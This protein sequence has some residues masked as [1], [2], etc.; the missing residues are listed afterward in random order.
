[1]EAEM[2]HASALER[3]VERHPRQVAHVRLVEGAV[4]LTRGCPTHGGR[5]ATFVAVHLTLPP[6][7]PAHLFSSSRSLSS[8][9]FRI[10][11]WSWSMCRSMHSR[12]SCRSFWAG[13]ASSSTEVVLPNFLARVSVCLVGRVGRFHCSTCSRVTAGRSK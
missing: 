8:A 2:M 11:S 1:M 13:I 3:R 6:Y 9:T 7:A 5:T 12:T 10:F 4:L